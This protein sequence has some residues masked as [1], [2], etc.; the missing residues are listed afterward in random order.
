MPDCLEPSTRRAKPRRL[1]LDIDPELH[2]WLKVKAAERQQTMTE[3][4]EESVRLN[5]GEP[6]AAIG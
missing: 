6:V 2:R 4:V 5:L 1:S 3:L